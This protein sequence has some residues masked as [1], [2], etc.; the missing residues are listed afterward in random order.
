[1]NLHVS[2]KDH[3]RT[4]Q[5]ELKPYEVIIQL[6]ALLESATILS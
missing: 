2:N 1:M 4:P 5:S 3:R 6:S